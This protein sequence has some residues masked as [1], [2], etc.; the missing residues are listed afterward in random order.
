[1]IWVSGR[2]SNPV[3]Y[4][5]RDMVQ[6]EETK[7]ALIAADYKNVRLVVMEARA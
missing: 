2:K 5:C 3:H 7:A 6:A 1:M 4:A